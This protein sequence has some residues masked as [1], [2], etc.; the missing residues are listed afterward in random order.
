M[1]KHQNPMPTVS[2][3]I[4]TDCFKSKSNPKHRFPTLTGAWGY[5]HHV[6]NICVV[7]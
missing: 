5:N 2:S 1:R 3:F 7:K 4:S 6:K